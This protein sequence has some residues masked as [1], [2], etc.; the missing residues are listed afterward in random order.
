MGQAHIAG[1]SVLP[2][3]PTCHPS[4]ACMLHALHH[5]IDVKA[6]T[7]ELRAVT[8][9]QSQPHLMMLQSNQ[10]GSRASWQVLGFREHMLSQLAEAYGKRDDCTGSVVATMFD[11]IGQGF[12]LS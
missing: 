1:H 7:S 12:V 9:Q 11:S 10:S 5:T 2:T 6:N 4:S 8:L 3:E